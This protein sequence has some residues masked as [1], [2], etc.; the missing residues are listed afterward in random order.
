[1]GRQIIVIVLLIASLFYAVYTYW[2]VLSPYLPAPK[3]AK[4]VAAAAPTITIPS[5]S[6]EAKAKEAEVLDI[7]LPTA[8]ARII[9]PF[10]L[11]ISVKTR[12]EEPL[13]PPTIPGEGKPKPAE[14]PVEPKLEG[15]WVDS[16][17][18][19]AFISGQALPVGGAVLGWKVVSI[20]KE[21]V[22]L[23][24]G[25]ATKTLRLEGK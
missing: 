16:G 3:K 7:L 13:P 5:A 21:Q 8:E 2:P 9:D 12:A 10:A 6:I 14:K 1:M 15:I 22:V 23:Q 24:K 19:I 20:S 4:P 11:R 25:S 17:M 18:K